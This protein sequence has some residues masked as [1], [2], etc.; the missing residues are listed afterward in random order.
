MLVV[1]L[2]K[3]K[4]TLNE[5]FSEMLGSWTKTILRFMYGDDVNIVANLNEDEREPEFVIRGKYK[6]NDTNY[7]INLFTKCSLV[8]K[9]QLNKTLE[10]SMA[11][12]QGMKEKLS[13]VS[14]IEILTSNKL[15]KNKLKVNDIFQNNK[16]VHMLIDIYLH[17]KYLIHNYR[18]QKDEYEKIIMNVEY[19]F[20]KSRFSLP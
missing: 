8:E 1:D 14:P 18:I 20:E 12:F 7:I 5:T 13:D 3:A 17:P 19:L 6:V 15:L 4:R 11:I 2:E 10:S 9:Q 16:I